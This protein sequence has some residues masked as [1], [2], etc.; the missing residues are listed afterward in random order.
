MATNLRDQLAA[1][2]L[3]EEKAQVNHFGY[4]EAWQLGVGLI[5]RGRRESLP[6]AVSVTLGRQRVFS[7][8]LEGTSHDN[9]LWLDRKIAVVETFAHSSFYIQHLFV[10]QGRDFRTESRLDP[11]HY[12]AAGGGFP[13]RAGGMLVGAVAVSGW[14]ERG[15]H[16]LAVESL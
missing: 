16:A 5:E 13:V 7:A 12:A 4:E 6:I 11:T 15:E 14:H 2:L 1:F 3:D 9:D 8:A 10:Q